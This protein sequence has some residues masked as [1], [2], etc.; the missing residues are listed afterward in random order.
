MANTLTEVYESRKPLWFDPVSG[1]VG[2]AQH[3]DK[4]LIRHLFCT[5]VRIASTVWSPAQQN[6]NS[7]IISWV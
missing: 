7:D 5:A 2:V 6:C 3:D 4:A 1:E